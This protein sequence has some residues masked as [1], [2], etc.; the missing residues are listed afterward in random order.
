MWRNDR[1]PL[2]AAPRKAGKDT[3]FWRAYRAG[4]ATTSPGD[5]S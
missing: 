5:A 2:V 4:V 1:A 3:S